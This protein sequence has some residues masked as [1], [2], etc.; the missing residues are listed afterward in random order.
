MNNSR[1]F[2]PPLQQM[3]YGVVGSIVALGKHPIELSHSRGEVCL[4]G[5]Y[6]KVVVGIHKA[7]AMAEP[8]VPFS[9]R[10]KD[11]QKYGPIAIIAKYPLPSV[12]P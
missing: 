11:L 12:A 2:S 8:V 10:R 6:E 7:V 3:T 9:Y 5:L 1:F 4:G